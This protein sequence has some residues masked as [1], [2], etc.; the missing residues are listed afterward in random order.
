MQLFVVVAV[1]LQKGDTMLPWCV[2]SAIKGIRLILT[3]F[4]LLRGRWGLTLSLFL[5]AAF[6]LFFGALY[7]MTGIMFDTTPLFQVI[8]G[9]FLPRNPIANMYFT[10]FGAGEQLV[11]VCLRHSTL[12]W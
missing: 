1:F 4:S 6:I 11:L 7:A 10:L 2:S 12:I 5:A 9:V 3:Y 8:G